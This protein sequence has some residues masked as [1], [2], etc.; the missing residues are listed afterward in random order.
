MVHVP[1]LGNSLREVRDQMNKIFEYLDE[2]IADHV[3][4][5]DS[6]APPSDYCEA[7]WREMER[8]KLGD[9]D[10]QHFFT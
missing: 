6:S 3:A 1:L 2:E 7:Y 5:A 9:T 4:N 8:R 10:E